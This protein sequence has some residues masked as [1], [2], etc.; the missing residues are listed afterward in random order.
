VYRPTLLSRVL[1]F[2]VLPGLAT[3]GE[4]P[5]AAMTVGTAVQ[6]ADAA[7]SPLA[8]PG[9]RVV[10][11]RRPVRLRPRPGSPRGRWLRPRTGFGSPQV[12][13]VADQRGDWLGVVSTERPNGRLGWL[14]RDEAGIRLSRTLW[15]LHADVSARRLEL[16]RNGRRQMTASVAVGSSSS[17]TPTDRFAVTDKLD[18]D[19]FGSYYGCCIIALSGH[20][21]RT[22]PGWRGGNRLA[23]HGTSAQAS[24][25]RA[26]SAGCLRASD[27]ALRSLMRR[28]P[29][30]TPVFIRR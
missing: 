30:G 9:F 4:D 28:V 27:R 10:R 18:G 17:P 3:A 21:T 22:P 2:A 29:L 23:I 24:I 6:P 16:R 8:R 25:G 20:Q 19:R 7:A 11:V 15:S 14:R 12:L 5:A 13:G 1:P 26:A